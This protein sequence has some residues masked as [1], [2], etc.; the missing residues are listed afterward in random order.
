MAIDA[1]AKP[2]AEGKPIVR[3]R[4]KLAA[5][6]WC[7]A[8]IVGSL[9]LRLP[10]LN[11]PMN[12]DEGGY[13][14]VAQRWF[15]GRGQL[16]QDIWLSR[17]QGIFVLYHL[18]FES[19]GTGAMALHIASWLTGLATTFFVWLFVREWLGE[20]PALAAALLFTL[21]S[22]SPYI[23]GY[24]ANAEVFMALPAAAA[25]WLMLRS[26]R[27]GWHW[28]SL[29]GI[30]LLAALATHLKPSGVV[31][32]P[33]GVAFAFMM[34]NGDW[35][36]AVKRSAWMTG[37]FA[38]GLAPAF[39]HGWLVGWDNFIYASLTY[40]LEFQSSANA[41]RAHHW[42]RIRDL[43]QH[44]RALVAAVFVVAS[45]RWTAGFSWQTVP[46]L[47]PRTTG[48]V[49]KPLIL[50]FAPPVRE[51]ASTETILLRLWIVSC[52]AGIAMGGDWW[53]H[54][55]IQIAA[56]LAIWLVVAFRDLADRLD[57]V[58][59]AGV[60]AIVVALLVAQYWV[61]VAGN[62]NA[63]SQ[64]L[65]QRDDYTAAPEIAAYLDEHTAPETPIYVAFSQPAIYY[66]SDLPAAYRYLYQQE[67]R[68]LPHAEDDLIAMVKSDDRPL[69]I[70]D[71]GQRAPVPDG[72][73]S[74]WTTVAQHYHLE[75][76]IGGVRIY[77]ANDY[78]AASR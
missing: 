24:T 46:N 73:L 4:P 34:A 54:Y 7:L 57:R 72:G 29:V 61:G 31:V 63:I 74:F 42:E 55:L 5:L 47:A 43:M 22:G 48:V 26:S 15:D 30:G 69:Y 32:L 8:F 17:S 35:R 67:L 75:T 41:T 25:A 50:G 27:R 28:S 68:A 38:A 78:A 16:Y 52:L 6:L 66:L 3:S 64:W 51:R 13:A 58:L 60:I 9:L 59:R 65:Y 1:H 44:C 37:A 70:V 20:K 39:I 33:L 10:F 40:R 62:A 76:E 14:Y 2:T 36:T 21:I 18:I 11:V 56:P 53:D 71:T 45:A 77:R 12:A 23:E 49:A 19:I